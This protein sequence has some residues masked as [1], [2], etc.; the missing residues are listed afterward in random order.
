MGKLIATDINGII[1]E[2]RIKEEDFL[3]SFFEL[4]IN[5]IQAIEEKGDHI[6]GRIDIYVER[7]EPDGNV[8][9]RRPISAVKVVDNGIG[10]TDENYNSFTRSHSTKK[11]DIG[12]K[13]VGRFAVLS[14]FDNIE[15]SSVRIPINGAH[16]HISFSLNREEGLSEPVFNDSQQQTGTTVYASGI[17]D[18]FKNC[19]ASYDLESIADSILDHCLL[20][21]LNQAAPI[22]VLHEGEESIN[23]SN[24]FSPS[25]FI[26]KTY[27]GRIKQCEFKLY[28][29]KRDKPKYHQYTL[30]ANNRVVRS[31]KISTV[32]PLFS[33][34]LFDDGIIKFLRIYVV[35]DYLNEIVNMSR[36]ELDF[37]KKRDTELQNDR[38][39]E[40]DIDSFIVRAI[41][42]AFSE[43][44][45]RR[46]EKCRQKIVDFMKK[47]VGLAYRH[48]EI[49]DSFLEGISDDVKEEEM[50]E[51]LHSLS[52]KQSVV[53]HNKC[54]KLLE[55]DYSNSDDYQSMLEDVINTTTTEGN[56][57]LAQYVSKRKTVIALFEKYL[58]WIEAS[59]E[60]TE[61][62]SLHNLLF[63]MGGTNSSVEYD[64]HNLWLLDDRLAFFGYISS[65]RAIRLHAPI[66]GQTTCG[67][68]TD[69]IVYDVP[70]VYGEKDDYGVINSVLIFELKRPDRIITYEEFGKQM[71]EQIGGIRSGKLK[72]DNGQNIRTNETVPIYFYYVCDDNAY[73]ALEGNAKLEGF[74]E[75]PFK[76][77]FRTVNNTTQEILT[78]NSMLVNA[79]RRNLVFFKKLG[80]DRVLN[81]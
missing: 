65:D 60:Y 51:K 75:T 79:K 8:F 27:S 44:I 26:D 38:I 35:S 13:G 33:S 12:G 34:P 81:Q 29:V 28:F 80:I 73:G 7:G 4:V 63:V 25:D 68:E 52:Y 70:F 6:D 64:K 69:I 56:I 66:E 20:Y 76:S 21:Y 46:K 15:I 16:N 59:N 3:L 1:H 39:Y 5:A 40:S 47:D 45:S 57:Q 67:K 42:E 9:G 58:Q 14:V 74:V 78:Y 77:L 72:S 53:S 41:S 43:D 48:L 19:S 24:Q 31:K 2:L 22:I 49:S 36:N 71:R 61:E 32:F 54:K 30:C 10:F 11:A 62:K 55:R 50:D 17:A 37:P 23:L 18:A